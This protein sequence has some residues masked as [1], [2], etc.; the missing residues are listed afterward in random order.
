MLQALLA[1]L[2]AALAARWGQRTIVATARAAL[3]PPQIREAYLAGH[4]EGYWNGVADLA[5]T[6]DFALR[7]PQRQSYMS[8][9]VPIPGVH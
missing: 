1:R 7:Q 9:A 2:R 8:V 3:L 5:S 6:S 4:R